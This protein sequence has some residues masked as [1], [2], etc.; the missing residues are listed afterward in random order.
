MQHQLHPPGFI[1]EP[2]RNH[3]GLCRDSSENLCT[4]G[5]IGQQLIGTRRINSAFFMK[6][7]TWGLISGSGTLLKQLK[8][9][10]SHV[11]HGLR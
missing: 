10:L 3:T 6:P 1:K 8:D 4:P 11:G 2:F 5:Y 7:M 9:P